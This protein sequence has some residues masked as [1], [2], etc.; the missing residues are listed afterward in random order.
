MKERLEQGQ[1]VIL[2]GG[3]G[4]ELSRRGVEWRYPELWSANGLLLS[5]DTVRT[6]HQDYILAGAEV[7]TTNTYNTHRVNLERVGIG[8]RTGELNRLAVHLAQEA[9]DNAGGDR[10]VLIAGAMAQLH[11]SR[12]GDLPS[13]ETARSVYR[14]QAEALAEAGVDL[15]L[16]ESLYQVFDAR[17]GAEAAAAT[18]L[19]TWVGIRCGSDGKVVSGENL[20]ELTESLAGMGVSAILIHHTD[21]QDSAAALSDL[22][23][24]YS[25]TTGI[26]PDTGQFRRPVW[27]ATDAISPPNF[28][29]YCRE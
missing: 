12:P 5:P 14:E 17:Y 7:I 16:I 13:V 26:Y 23:Q 15:F 28:L 22:Q 1:V 20:S 10:E 24:A 21:V 8:D 29:E 3:I 19:P 4:A 2:D 9:R 25:G 27:D 18:G 11:H 6:L